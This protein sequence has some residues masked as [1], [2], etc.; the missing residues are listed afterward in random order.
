MIRT[1]KEVFIAVA[2]FILVLFIDSVSY[3]YFSYKK[4]SD[5]QQ[6]IAGDIYFRLNEGDG[7]IFL[8]NTFPESK[9]EARNRIDNY[10]TFSISGKNTSNKKLYYDFILNYGTDY[11]NPKLRYNDK[12]LV[13]DLVELDANGNEINYL[14]D[15]VSFDTL[16]NRRIYVN[17]IDANTNSE[18]IRY[19]K[20]RMWLNENVII[21][22]SKLDASYTTDEYKNRYATIRLIASS[23]FSEKTMS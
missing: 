1:R 16:V 6:I 9:E 14:L 11:G 8:F 23:D 22:D 2:V 18:I 13:F 5:S 12:D 3:S 21:S 15:S 20:L 4:T 7:E 19:Y 10:I 17:M